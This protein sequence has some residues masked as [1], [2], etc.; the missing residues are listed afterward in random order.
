MITNNIDFIHSYWDSYIL[1]L[2]E[3]YC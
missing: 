1:E 3:L 2:L